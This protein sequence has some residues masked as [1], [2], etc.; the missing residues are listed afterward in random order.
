MEIV[1]SVILAILFGML[2]AVVTTRRMLAKHHTAAA[3]RDESEYKHRWEEALALLA[4]EGKLTDEQLAK[5][6]PPAP[7][8]LKVLASSQSP[9]KLPKLS[10]TDYDR[11]QTEIQRAKNG[12]P[13]ADS[14]EG[15]SSF[16]Y[17]RVLQARIKYA[18][19]QQQQ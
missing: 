16:D 13:P 6:A 2:A 4:G 19:L 7:Q 11:A 8:E 1:L 10:G 9:S 3:L 17:H 15:M 12:L 5:L 14:L 18:Y